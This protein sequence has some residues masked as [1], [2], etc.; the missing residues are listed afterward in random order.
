M[1]I[2]EARLEDAVDLAKV[3]ID[4][5]RTTYQG[6]IPDDYL[7]KMSYEEREQRWAAHFATTQDSYFT[8]VALDDSEKIV[9]FIRGG[10]YRESD[11]T[12]DGELHAIY[13]LK[14][15]QGKGIGHQLTQTLIKRL[16]EV[17]I[18]SMILWV[19]AENQ[20]ARR[21]Y[22]A[23]GGQYVKSNRFEIRGA[24][25]EEVAYGWMDISVLLK[26]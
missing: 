9:G 17:G 20:A 11:P 1:I 16:L 10:T 24:M 14:E 8:F 13:I 5:W 15:Y 6:I 26:E 7:A 21:F 23:L 3:Q 12:Y 2:R 25:I 18:Q 19:F 4:T 22:E